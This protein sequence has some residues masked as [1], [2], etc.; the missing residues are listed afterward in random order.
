MN[1]K[2]LLNI[3]KPSAEL[4][5]KILSY[6]SL[7]NAEADSFNPLWLNIPFA[8]IYLLF[9]KL[10]TERLSSFTINLKF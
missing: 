8:N 6:A 5:S 10:I 3:K 7:K 4:D 9:Y 1:R 2:R